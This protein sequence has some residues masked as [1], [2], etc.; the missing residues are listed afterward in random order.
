MK[1]TPPDEDEQFR[2]RPASI[3][4]PPTWGAKV[5]CRTD[6]PLQRP[7]RTNAGR[8]AGGCRE[9]VFLCDHIKNVDGFQSFLQTTTGAMLCDLCTD[10]GA[11]S[12]IDDS[13]NG[14]D[15][16]KLRARVLAPGAGR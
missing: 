1:K 9:L 5:K 14:R 16:D 2:A 13:C 11:R 3:A 7:P 4:A 15:A 10:L 6:K 8:T 12:R